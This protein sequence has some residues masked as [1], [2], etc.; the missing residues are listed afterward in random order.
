MWRK[1]KDILASAEM[2]L[3]REN[4]LKIKFTLILK[5]QK[6]RCSPI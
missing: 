3:L 6:H 2:V 4:P 1:I 5:Y